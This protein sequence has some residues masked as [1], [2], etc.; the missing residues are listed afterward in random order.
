M[1]GAGGGDLSASGAGK[2]G[3][4]GAPRLLWAA[5]AELGE[6]PLWDDAAGRV[7][8]LDIEGKR[9]HRADPDGEDR[10]SWKL[11]EHAGFAALTERRGTL[12]LGLQSGLH[13][14]APDAVPAGQEVGA[15]A[16]EFLARPDPDGPDIRPNDAAVDG[17]GRLWFGT[18]QTSEREGAGALHMMGP[19]A[20][21]RCVAQGWTIPNGPAL[22]ADGS[23]LY[24]TDSHR[25]SVFA[26]D[27]DDAGGASLRGQRL[28][29][30]LREE[31]KGVPDGMAADAEGCLWIAHNGGGRLVRYAPDG[32]ALEQ[33]ALPCPAVS[34]CAFGGQDLSTLFVTT[35]RKGA[36]DRRD[37]EACGALF[38]VSTRTRG[39][40]AGRLRLDRWH[41]G[42][43]AAA[44]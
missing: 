40:P 32:A 18:M 43:A 9:L 34:S 42:G 20:A 30:R 17:A 13:L 14:F 2:P 21:C 29:L 19:D 5:G 36:G 4:A 44:R 22:P 26:F 12:L 41:G 16:L 11:P 37:A 24:W 15:D 6:G 10:R 28:F 1:T 38:A 8:W 33:V 35:A 31:E 25:R 7:Y 3:V 27:H 39:L 23:R